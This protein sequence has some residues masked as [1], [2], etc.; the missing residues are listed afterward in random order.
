[1]GAA[2][3]P[4]PHLDYRS[5]PGS[6]IEDRGE[7]P[8]PEVLRFKDVVDDQALRAVWSGHEFFRVSW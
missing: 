2:L 8:T 5:R 3:R 7:D 4:K 6:R 1:M